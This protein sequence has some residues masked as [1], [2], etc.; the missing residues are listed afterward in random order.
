MIHIRVDAATVAVGGT[1]TGAVQWQ[2]D[3]APRRLIVRLEWFTEGRGDPNSGVVAEQVWTAGDGQL[4]LPP[5][6]DFALAVPPS[7]PCSYDGQLIRV[8]WRVTARLDLP[9]ARDDK[10]EAP[11]TVLPPPPAT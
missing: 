2:S 6:V 1:V 8:R 11:V 10:A 4:G 5:A 3:K 9:L 7:G